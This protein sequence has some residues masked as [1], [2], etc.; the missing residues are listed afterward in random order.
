MEL[1]CKMDNISVIKVTRVV[2]LSMYVTLFE[3]L[4][5]VT[6]EHVFCTLTALEEKNKESV[7]AKKSQLQLK[8]IKSASVISKN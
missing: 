3:I 4:N 1:V 6:T 8:H 7:A 2:I 5:V